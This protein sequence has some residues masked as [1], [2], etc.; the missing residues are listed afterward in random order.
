M[1]DGSQHHVLN[2]GCGGSSPDSDE[3]DET[4]TLEPGTHT[5]RIEI[6]VDAAG[7]FSSSSATTDYDLKLRF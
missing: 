4:G 5:I 1:F 2:P 3:L 6:D 7:D